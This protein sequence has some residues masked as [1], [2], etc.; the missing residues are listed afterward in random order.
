[1][2]HIILPTDFSP[3]SLK[4]AVF[5]FDLF[6]TIGN[7]YTLVHA[8]LKP[9]YNDPLL[10]NYGPAV[11]RAA[12][13]GLRDFEVR[14]REIAGRMDISGL[15]TS[16]SLLSTLEEVRHEQPVDLIV[17]GTQGEGNYGLVGRNSTAV[18][19]GAKRPVI[20]VP[21]RWK[22]GQIKRILLAYDLGPIDAKDME[23][24]L[25]I[26]RRAK[27]HVVITHVRRTG[28]TE[29]DLAY[30]TQFDKL[31]GDVPHSFEEV[32]GDSVD[33]VLA[34]KAQHGEVDM[35]M[36][37]HRQLGLLKGLFHT[38]ISKHL[39]LHTHVPLLVVPG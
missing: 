6:G 9:A 26:A 35:V 7:T 15:A 38:S 5:A 14:C 18:I 31:L 16:R 29:T 28:T 12:K 34:E 11:E 4:A 1:M 3:T 39:S 10:P 36:V 27:S 17:M 37:M 24:L 13:E 33:H 19:K 2:A 32:V 23:T 8:F 21:S 30:R 20:T 25:E 22:P